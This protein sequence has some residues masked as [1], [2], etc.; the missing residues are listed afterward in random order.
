MSESSSPM[1]ACCGR[2]QCISSE[3]ETGSEEVTNAES[4]MASAT[5]SKL[6][7][8]QSVLPCVMMGSP[9]GPSQQSSSTERQPCSSSRA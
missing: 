1:R 9:S 3:S 4:A 5:L 7:D 2:E 8:V 6:T